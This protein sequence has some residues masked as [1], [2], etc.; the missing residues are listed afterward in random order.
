MVEVQVGG[1]LGG[2][3]M[4]TMTLSFSLVCL[5]KKKKI[6]EATTEVRKALWDV[7]GWEV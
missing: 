3:L 4:Q 5:K 6:E 1:R 7:W 2:W